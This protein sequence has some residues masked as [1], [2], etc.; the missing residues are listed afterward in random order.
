MGFRSRRDS[1]RH[2]NENDFHNG[3]AASR[4]SMTSSDFRKHRRHS[5]PATRSHDDQSGQQ[6]PC[7]R[8]VMTSASDHVVTSASDQ[9]MT[10]ASDQ[11][12]TSASDHVMTSASEHAVTDFKDEDQKKIKESFN[13]DQI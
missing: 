9:V 8:T 12:I 3:E 4:S 10:S 11:V 1:R 13:S 5:P 7:S 6:L 2:S